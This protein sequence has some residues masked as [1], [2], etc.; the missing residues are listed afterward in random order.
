M[1]PPAS[2]NE[3]EATMNS[4]LNRRDRAGDRRHAIAGGFRCIRSEV[5]HHRLLRNKRTDRPRD[6]E[7]REQAENHMLARIPLGQRQCFLHRPIETRRAERKEIEAG[8]DCRHQGE[9][10][11]FF[12]GVH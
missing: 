12:A 4:E 7:R 2:T 11:Q 1:K 9:N 10:R 6:P 3:P 8:K 5:T